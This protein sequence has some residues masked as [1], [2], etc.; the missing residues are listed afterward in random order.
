MRL[1]S[2]ALVMAT[3]IACA[4]SVVVDPTI[5]VSAAT[6]PG[7]KAAADVDGV[8]RAL[9]AFEDRGFDHEPVL[10]ITPVCY[11]I[12]PRTRAIPEFAIYPDASLVA[13]ERGLPG[14]ADS[15]QRTRSFRLSSEDLDRLAHLI[16]AGGLTTGDVHAAGTRSGVADGDGV[17]FEALIGSART[18]VHAPLL[19][20]GDPDPVREALNSLRTLLRSYTETADGTVLPTRWVMVGEPYTDPSSRPWQ[21][22]GHPTGEPPCLE[23]DPSEL[24]PEFAG[25]TSQEEH[26]VAWVTFDRTSYA[27]TG[28]PLLPHEDDCGDVQNHLSH[29]RAN[30][31]ALDLAGE[32]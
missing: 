11:S 14:D 6:S 26:E 8:R 7:S 2:T 1:V 15:P 13:I 29:I 9:S 20:S 3:M 19:D 17:I 18:Y 24:P 25:L 21:G 12:C 30:D 4:G 16:Q 31:D 32:G 27:M 22:G 10:T 28:R 5:P 23:F